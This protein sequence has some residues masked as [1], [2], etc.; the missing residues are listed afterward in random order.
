MQKIILSKIFIV[1]FIIF[2]SLTNILQFDIWSDDVYAA[3]DG[4]GNSITKSI[5]SETY[6]WVTFGISWSITWWVSTGWT[7]EDH[8]GDNLTFVSKNDWNL[9]SIT[10]FST[11]VNTLSW[12]ANQS[13]WSLTSWTIIVN[14]TKDDNEDYTNN[15][16]LSWNI[17]SCMQDPTY[18]YVTAEYEIEP[19]VVAPTVTD[20][21]IHKIEWNCT[22]PGWTHFGTSINSY[23]DPWSWTCNNVSANYNVWDYV[24]FTLYVHN[25]W[26]V[27]ANN[28][29]V[30]D[31]FDSSILQFMNITTNGFWPHSYTNPY[32]TIWWTNGFGLMANRGTF[33]ILRYQVIADEANSWTTQ[34]Q[35]KTWIMSGSQN[36]NWLLNNY[37]TITFPWDTVPSNNVSSDN[38]NIIWYDLSI[39]KSRI[40]GTEVWWNTVTYRLSFTN[41]GRARDDIRVT[42]NFTFGGVTFVSWSS[43]LT[44]DSPTTLN[45][46]DPAANMLR[47][48]IHMSANQSSY[49]DITVTLPIHIDYCTVPP[50]YQNH[51]YIGTDAGTINDMTNRNDS[52]I[53]NNN[54]YLTLSP[55]GI[56]TSGGVWC[57][58]PNVPYDLIVQSKTS[59]KSLVTVWDKVTY[60]LT[61]Y[62]SGIKDKRVYLQD[63]YTQGM[64][65]DK[66]VLDPSR[67][68][69]R[70]DHPT[71]S[72]QVL[73]TIEAPNYHFDYMQ[74][75]YW[76]YNLLASPSISWSNTWYNIFDLVA[77]N[78]T[79]SWICHTFYDTGSMYHTNYYDIMDI[80]DDRDEIYDGYISSGNSV[81]QAIAMTM[82]D[83]YSTL[84]IYKQDAL[85]NNTRNTATLYNQAY[86]CHYRAS[87][88]LAIEHGYSHMDAQNYALE[89]APSFANSLSNIYNLINYNPTYLWW[90]NK[91]SWLI[92]ALIHVWYDDININ[93][94]NYTNSIQTWHD[95]YEM[96]L[97]P[98]TTYIDLAQ[99]NTN[100]R[101]PVNYVTW[102]SYSSGTTY[103]YGSSTVRDFDNF[104]S[105]SPT[106]TFSWLDNNMSSINPICNWT[107][108]WY[109]I[110]IYRS[111]VK[112]DISHDVLYFQSGWIVESN[113]M[114]ESFFYL[115]ANQSVQFQYT[116][117]VWNWYNSGDNITN[118][119][120]IAS[121]QDANCNWLFN[122]NG[123]QIPWTNN[124]S[125]NNITYYGSPTD[126]DLSWSHHMISIN[127]M[128][129]QIWSQVTYDM[130]YC[131]NG[132]DTVTWATITY[133]YDSRL[134]FISSS[135]WSI[136][137][138]NNLT[139]EY[140]LVWDSYRSLSSW[141]CET[142]QLKFDIN[143]ISNT[144]NPISNILHVGLDDV[145][146]PDWLSYA[147]DTNFTNNHVLESFIITNSISTNTASKRLEES[148]EN[149]DWKVFYI[150][151]SWHG[152]NTTIID[153]FNPDVLTFISASDGWVLSGTDQVIWSSIDN[154]ITWEVSVTFSITTGAT[155]WL[156]TNEAEIIWNG[157]TFCSNYNT[158]ISSSV[159]WSGVTPIDGLCGEASGDVIYNLNNGRSWLDENDLTLCASG[160]VINFTTG[161]TW[162][163]HFRSWSCVWTWW[164][165]TVSCRADELY[166]GDGITQTDE[167]EQCD[168]QAWCTASCTWESF[169]CDDFWLTADPNG[170]T[171]WTIIEWTWSDLTWYDI[172]V[173]N[174][175]FWANINDPDS[176]QST[177]Y[178]T[179]W[180]FTGYILVS[181]QGNP[182][183]S[184]RCEAPVT[185]SANPINGICG[186]ADNNIYYTWNIPNT[187]D[188]CSQWN[189][190]DFNAT[191]TWWTW[192]C[193]GI[194]GWTTSPTCNASKSYCG[195]GVIG[196]GIWYDNDERCDLWSNNWDNSACSNTCGWNTPICHGLSISPISWT[197]WDTYNI[198]WSGSTWA[199]GE[200]FITDFGTSDVSSPWSTWVQFDTIWNKNII[201]TL[202]NTWD[203]STVQCTWDIS[204]EQSWAPWV[205]GSKYNNK[206]VSFLSPMTKY[207]CDI[208]TVIWFSTIHNP[209]WSA[210]RTWNCNNWWVLS[211]QCSAYKLPLNPANNFDLSINKYITWWA[212]DV[213]YIWDTI[214]YEI[215]IYNSGSMIWADIILEDILPEWFEFISWSISYISWNNI[216]NYSW[217]ID[218]MQIWDIPYFE[219]NTSIIISYNVLITWSIAGQDGIN[220]ASIIPPEG[221]D[222]AIPYT[223][224][225]CDPS[226]HNPIAWDFAVDNTN[227]TDCVQIYIEEDIVYAPKLNIQK[228]GSLEVYNSWD[229]IWYHISITNDGNT[230]AYDIVVTEYY[231]IWFVYQ[232]HEV[233]TWNYDTW[234]KEWTIPYIWTD[235]IIF[236]HIT[237]TLIW[238]GDQINQAVITSGT[239]DTC[240]GTRETS[241]SGDYDLSIIK[242][243]I[244][245]LPSIVY[246][247]DQIIYTLTYYNYSTTWRYVMIED[248]Y[249]EHH[250]YITWSIS[251]TDTHPTSINTWSRLIAWSGVWLD[252]MT[253]WVINITFQ[254]IWYSGE[255]FTNTGRIWT[256]SGWYITRESETNHDN[257]MDNATWVIIYI[258]TIDYSPL[259]IITKSWSLVTYTSGDAITY[260]VVLTNTGNTW[261]R[262]VI[263][264]EY[265]PDWFVF[266]GVVYET[267]NN[268]YTGN[269]TNITSTW[270]DFEI[271]YIDVWQVFD[272]IITGTLIWTGDQINQAVIT[273]GS[274][275]T[276]TGTRETDPEPP[277]PP[278]A[279]TWFDLYKTVDKPAV[280]SWDVVTWTLYYQNTGNVLCTDMKII[281]YIPDHFIYWWAIMS[282]EIIT[283]VVW[284]NPTTYT[285]SIWDLDIWQT[286]SIIIT[287][288]VW[289]PVDTIITNT[290]VLYS[291]GNCSGIYVTGTVNT[292]ILTGRNIRINKTVNAST[293][294]VWQSV[295]WKLHYEN[296][297]YLTAYDVK[298]EDT[299]PAD[300]QYISASQTPN[301]PLSS[302][303]LTWDIGILIPWQTW[304]ITI[305]TKA[306]TVWTYTNY[307]VISS[308]DEAY[309]WD[310]YDNVSIVVTR[311]PSCTNCRAWG[312]WVPT[313]PTT[314]PKEPPRRVI[315]IIKDII[316]IPPVK[317]IP[318]TGADR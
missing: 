102:E 276:C 55:T 40:S 22:P 97:Y 178:N 216:I 48:G 186:S 219:N 88:E 126:Y 121:C 104:I 162:L 280:Y 68:I 8:F 220:T 30:A 161:A 73:D 206:Q 266:G 108:W 72:S 85:N 66:I 71:I 144:S 274:C 151:F 309:T 9:G 141:Q 84:Y 29:W 179:E 239:C 293:V 167:W 294:Q 236:M 157:V 131:N 1:I 308:P 265:F 255:V 50:T 103:K 7:I 129:T 6:T 291:D 198:S 164:G 207:L 95:I 169:S 272:F 105:T 200:L 241:E 316:T 56:T 98:T 205:C 176:G 117:I 184:G 113:S 37:N 215:E 211:E 237:G 188:L 142:I 130:T 154:N 233:S 230:W 20:L 123:E 307:V 146:D 100:T 289:W 224:W 47:D 209:D 136:W 79:G 14:F 244:V 156:Y 46:W 311:V 278:T 21:M 149:P 201:Y 305:T 42:D 140:K 28:I 264:T 177:W 90:K 115:P 138:V 150:R 16:S 226:N 313:T 292:T 107:Y 271:D 210:T 53:T 268:T 170:G 298:I 120:L 310:N 63:V 52:N 101:W 175:G 192:N 245:P 173:F 152:D 248:E 306:L 172:D 251:G 218:N 283:G 262:D 155:P 158:N 31:K 297:S 122:R 183:I 61:L 93:L 259:L 110:P 221:S 41:N 18:D 250:I 143:S 189:N 275:D 109:D 148:K 249:D 258:P 39:T 234:T 273:S 270:F 116:M 194:N 19:P 252:A 114:P 112:D 81:G 27:V 312:W 253:T 137:S 33:A 204:V 70:W 315:D 196:T 26:A 62:N 145:S 290:W 256:N 24:Y 242:D 222:E 74:E 182:S 197:T 227:N 288:I 69:K 10:V 36:Y 228:N 12:T 65:F 67:F 212:E 2:N 4:L 213:A 147:W 166:C 160:D 45:N 235:Q 119:A 3:S 299:L 86:A 5:I 267:N 99:W 89:E 174:F 282:G 231:P 243:I 91:I 44:I 43:P 77:S 35:A 49:I 302:N 190:I 260:Q 247:G 225:V 133:N 314:D 34:N 165:T 223:G 139:S 59:D 232:S 284:Y 202:T 296:N 83:I 92:S 281:D 96:F 75:L 124:T 25:S 23:Q 127:P 208:W 181:N 11:G 15:V 17:V 159:N 301:L 128:P 279:H 60:T 217:S 134:T 254:V 87:Y 118:E 57:E 238:T 13:S 94:A 191:A 54:D 168:G 261:E 76:Q 240:T 38:I 111:I 285:Y 171:T 32:N 300:L 180:I 132:P 153:T 263:I 187:G 229:T 58:I 80:Y 214:T 82:A 125:I 286:W 277:I 163:E 193:E 199:N 304:S 203:N 135:W 195:D 106:C 318:K 246:S 78:P 295:I 287:G 64:I 51:A 185:I 317:I 269:F 303:K 257:N